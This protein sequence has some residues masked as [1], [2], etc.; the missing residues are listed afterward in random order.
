MTCISMKAMVLLGA[1]LLL[2]AVPTPA[3]PIVPPAAGVT[4]AYIYGIRADGELVWYRHDGAASGSSV[5]I[6][7]AWQGPRPVDSGWADFKQ[8]FAGDNG[9]LYAI[10]N[11]GILRLYQHSGFETGLTTSESGWLP[12]QSLSKGWGNFKQAFSGGGGVLYAITSDGILK[13]YKHGVANGKVTWEGPKDVGTGW[14]KFRQVYSGGNGVLYAL[15]FNGKLMWYRH[16]AYLSGDAMGTPGAWQGAKEVGSGWGDFKQVACAGDGLFYAI[17]DAGELVWYREIGHDTGIKAWLPQKVVSTGW[18]NYQRVF[19]SLS[20]RP[21]AAAPSRFDS[22]ITEGTTSGTGATVQYLKNQ[23]FIGDVVVVP[24][25]H[26]AAFSFS[27]TQNTK[28]LIEIGKVPAEYDPVQHIYRFPVN[29]AAFSRFVPPAGGGKYALHIGQNTDE[30]EVGSTYYYIVNVFNN[31]P[32]DLKRPREQATGKFTTQP[33]TVKVVWEKISLEHDNGRIVWWFWANYG[34]PSRKESEYYNGDMDDRHDYYLGKDQSVVI[35][36]APDQLSLAAS[37]AVETHLFLGG[38]GL[39]T[40]DPDEN[41]E[42]RPLNGPSDVVNKW[43]DLF[44]VNAAKG[45]FNLTKYPGKNV[46]VPF[47]LLSMPHGDLRFVVFGHFEI[48]RF[49][50]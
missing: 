3:A 45:E 29:S 4:P 41:G 7:G 30:L 35:E 23:P 14:D 38:H 5:T 36:N 33:Q 49:T 26:G 17:T 11:D 12:P 28:P 42:S 24:D 32:K 9:S 8:V 21:V 39:W 20:S 44:D 16:V 50:P 22:A 47:K 1:V 40:Q 37:G 46:S 27:S 25:L 2:P 18:N 31:N 34:Q 43:P 48:T 6:P 15:T 10:T 19:A 13:W